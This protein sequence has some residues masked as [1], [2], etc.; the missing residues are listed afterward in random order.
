M[1]GMKRDVGFRCGGI[2]RGMSGSPLCP[3]LLIVVAKKGKVY[4]YE[5]IEIL[6]EFGFSDLLPDITTVYKVMRFLESMGWVISQWDTQ[7]NGPAKRVYEITQEG[8]DVLKSFYSKIDERK[9]IFERF[10]EEYKN[11]F[12]G[13]L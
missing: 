12:G 8:I 11:L 3:F 7:G 9:K 2:Q 10:V 6:K 1:W 4:G 13:S 5:V